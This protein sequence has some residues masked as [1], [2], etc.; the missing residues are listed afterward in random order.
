MKELNATTS[1]EGY[2]TTGTIKIDKW[3]KKLYQECTSLSNKE[4]KVKLEKEASTNFESVNNDWPAKDSNVLTA[5]NQK[6]L[7]S[8]TDSLINWENVTPGGLIHQWTTLTSEIHWTI[9]SDKKK[10]NY[11]ELD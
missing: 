11:E 1:R 2:D 4:I 9:S 3:L 6:S 5:T 8:N 7:N 10:T